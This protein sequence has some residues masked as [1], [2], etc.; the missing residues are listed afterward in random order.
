MMNYRKITLFIT[1]TFVTFIALC[2]E[3]K[4]DR[5]TEIFETILWLDSKI[6]KYQFNGPDLKCEYSLEY[7]KNDFIYFLIINETQYWPSD[8]LY[9]KSVIKI[10][11]KDLQEIS[12]LRT[13]GGEWSKENERGYIIDLKTINGK[14]S[15]KSNETNYLWGQNKKTEEEKNDFYINVKKSIDEENLNERFI[16]AFNYIISLSKPNIKEKF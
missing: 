4:I 12:Y 8:K 13:R 1:F 3:K 7:K 2:Q 11:L 14:H 10:P 6:Q 16:K 5:D 15:I 9:S